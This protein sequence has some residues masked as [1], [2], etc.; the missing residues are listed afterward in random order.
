MIPNPD[1]HEADQE[2]MQ[3]H[4]SR[5]HTSLRRYMVGKLGVFSIVLGTGLKRFEQ[6]MRPEQ[7]LTKSAS[8]LGSPHH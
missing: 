3:A 8:S 4:L 7:I 6:R 2:R 5:Q 1:Q